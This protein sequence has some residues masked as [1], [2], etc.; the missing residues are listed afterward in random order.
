MTGLSFI[1]GSAL[2]RRRLLLGQ[3]VNVAATQEQLAARDHH[4]LMVGEDPC[5]DRS[6]FGIC[7]VVEA[8]GNDATV[9]NQE[10]HVR[11]RQAHRRVT[12]WPF[13]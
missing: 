5:Q 11:T 1:T 2:D 10:V 3:A 7:R 13:G 9:N 4:H 8:W 12:P 6:G